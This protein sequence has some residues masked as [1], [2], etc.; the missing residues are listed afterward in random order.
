MKIHYMSDL[1][2]DHFVFT[3]STP[4]R[5]QKQIDVYF[6]LMG[7]NKI[8]EDERYMFIIPG[9]LSNYN[10]VAKDVLLRLKQ[11][12]K[13]VILVPGNH[14]RYLVSG[15]QAKKY[16]YFSQNRIDELKKFCS[17]ND[18]IFLDG[19]IVEIDGK[20]FAGLSMFWDKFYYN[21]LE[22]R[23]AS[24]AEVLNFYDNYMNDSKFIMDGHEPHKISLAYGGSYYNS[25]FNAIKFFKQ[26]YEKL[27][28]LR[29]YDN[30]DVMITHYVPTIPYGMKR[31]Y[32]EERGT[33]FYM[34]D[35]EKDIERISPA[36]W[37]FGHV[38][39]KYN[40]IHKNVKFLCNPHGYPGETPYRVD[41]F[42]L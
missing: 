16:K 23:E 9:D 18:I 7:L 37:L 6:E 28:N 19:N 21:K 4:S 32:A 1:H 39:N 26:E 22:K 14:D 17:D 24:D 8:P 30:I 40:F 36:V 33:T 3:A 15:E 29:D 25:S 12:F 31:E 41:W 42:E 5:R 34:F 10:S 20:K 13:Y 27:Q 2:V 11:L 35:G 38:H